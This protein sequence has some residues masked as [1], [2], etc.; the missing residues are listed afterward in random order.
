MSLQEKLELLKRKTQKPIVKS[1]NQGLCKASSES[2]QLNTREN[3][4]AMQNALSILKQKQSYPTS[5]SMKTLSK[6]IRLIIILDNSL[7]MDGTEE[8]IYNGVKALC[9]KHQ[10]DNIILTWVVFNDEKQIIY[11]DAPISL[12][13]AKMIGTMGNTNLNGTLYEIIKMYGDF[14]D[15]HNLFV[16]ISDGSDNLRKV[17]PEQVANLMRRTSIELNDFYFLGEANDLTPEEAV[18]AQAKS[19]G[20]NRNNIEVFT[21]EA[22]GNKLNFDVISNML[23]DLLKKGKIRPN[24]S[25]PIKEHYLS[26]TD[27]RRK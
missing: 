23:D 3:L 18:I 2:T 26:L 15:T 6:K 24:W 5:F 9:E 1:S 4:S 27:K 7:S 25:E 22:S 13:T 17:A 14:D 8:D 11:K 12:V 20:F 19:L 16:I 21:R 10:N